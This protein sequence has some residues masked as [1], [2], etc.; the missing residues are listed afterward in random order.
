MKL[1]EP[2]TAGNPVTIKMMKTW[3]YTLNIRNTVTLCGSNET[4][5]MY[6]YSEP[7]ENAFYKTMFIL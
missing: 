6:F 2:E 1:K 3:Q 7:T 5:Q 4:L